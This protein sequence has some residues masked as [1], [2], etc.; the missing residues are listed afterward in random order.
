MEQR[1]RPTGLRSKETWD[2]TLGRVLPSKGSQ[3][4][5]TVIPYVYTL[6]KPRQYTLRGPSDS[7]NSVPHLLII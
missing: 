2:H 6:H 4:Y 5:A 3:A 1:S 7:D